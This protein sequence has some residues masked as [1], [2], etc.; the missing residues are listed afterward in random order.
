M[1]TTV[2]VEKHVQRFYDTTLELGLNTDTAVGA[3]L[4]GNYEPTTKRRRVSL[5]L[6]PDEAAASDPIRQGKIEAAKRARKLA[7][8]EAGMDLTT[9][10]WDATFQRETLVEVL[11]ERNES[12]RIVA[13]EIVR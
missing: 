9:I 6:T 2:T 5:L 3:A 7:C 8:R 11:V 1:A 12:G 4:A 13:R 10:D